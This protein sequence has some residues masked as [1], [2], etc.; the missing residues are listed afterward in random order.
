MW[1]TSDS[2]N[3]DKRKRKSRPK[4]IFCR[5]A[6]SLHQ[7][8]YSIYYRDWGLERICSWWWKTIKIRPLVLKI[9]KTSTFDSKGFPKYICDTRGNMKMEPPYHEYRN[10]SYS[11]LFRLIGFAFL[12]GI[13]WNCL[14]PICS[15][16]FNSS[17]SSIVNIPA[18]SA[19]L[20][21]AST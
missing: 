2:C 21:M 5:R 19:A 11:H 16:N 20:D 15:H 18:N 7:W 3:F 6:Q 17:S 1:N 13:F 9:A 14:F 4:S 8:G 10:W 12:I